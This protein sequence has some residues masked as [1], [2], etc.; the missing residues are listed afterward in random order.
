MWVISKWVK[1]TS[2]ICEELRLETYS[3]KMWYGFMYISDP[4]PGIDSKHS[5]RLGYT[6]EHFG[7]SG[8]NSI[9]PKLLSLCLKYSWKYKYAES[10]RNQN[11]L[12]ECFYREKCFNCVAHTMII[13]R[14]IIHQIPNKIL[15]VLRIIYLFSK[16]F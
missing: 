3:M 8:H 1:Q 2:S 5:H 12:Y 10:S 11:N 15:V 16:A 4:E 6:C 7:K 9:S 13:P 14:E